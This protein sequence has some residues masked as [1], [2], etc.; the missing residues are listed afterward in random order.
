MSYDDDDEPPS[1]VLFQNHQW[2][3]T[4]YGVEAVKPAPYYHFD[5]TRL[6]EATD[7]G[8]GTMYDWPVHMAEKTWVD[9]EAFIEV[10]VKALDLHAGSY[11]GTVDKGMLA[12]SLAT[13]RKE[14]VRR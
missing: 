8:S 10:F 3:V 9:I 4:D 7:H 14:A 11:G 5:K 13:A 12:K 6:L 1:K 2:S